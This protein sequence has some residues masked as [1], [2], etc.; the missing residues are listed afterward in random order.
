MLSPALIASGFLLLGQ[1]TSADTLALAKKLTK[2]YETALAKQ[3]IKWFETHT[4]ADYVN[5]T[6]KGERQ[7]RDK[8]L[9]SLRNDF[10]WVDK[11][12]KY[13]MTVVGAKKV[14]GGLLSST[15]TALL[16]KCK[17]SM[18]GTFKKIK[19]LVELSQVEEDAWLFVDGDW[20]LRQ[21]VTKSSVQKIGGK[22]V[23]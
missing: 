3:D 14:G 4:G 15:P 16:V 8:A 2:Q 11:M 23:K 20:I 10:S 7:T 6:S 5:V 13:Q 12:S 9:Q 1:S 22:I 19:G 21:T 17:V 18:V